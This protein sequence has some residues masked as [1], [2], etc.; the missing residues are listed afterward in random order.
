MLNAAVKI[1]SLVSQFYAIDP[2]LVSNEGWTIT[3]Q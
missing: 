1:S 2:A 3:G